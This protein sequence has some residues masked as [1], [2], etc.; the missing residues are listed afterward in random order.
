MNCIISE[1]LKKDNSNSLYKETKSYEKSIVIGLAVCA[2][3]SGM[4]AFAQENE[5]LGTPQITVDGERVELEK[6]NLTEYMFE[7]NSTVMVPVR[8]VA[9]KMGYTVG[10]DEANRA[11]TVET[12]NWQAMAYI[13]EDSYV[14]VSKTA[15]GMTAPVIIDGST[16]VPAKMFELMD[17]TYTSVGQYLDFKKIENT[18]IPNPFTSYESID[19]LQKALCFNAI[20]PSYLPDGYK[21]DDISAIGND[22][23]QIIYHD[24]NDNRLSYRMAK[25]SEDISGDYNVYDDTDTIAA[26][27]YEVTIKGSGGK[28]NCALWND[29]ETAYSIGSSEGLGRDQMQDIAA[30]I[31]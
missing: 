27:D 4:T 29:G 9:E 12:D 30:G 20:V 11:V 6:T 31:R 25:G 13:G 5:I 28:Y 14:G 18:Q 3:L 22:F 10:W 8:A 1:D 24:A 17:Y 2:L 21:I 19:E 15:I 23:M 7:E 26:G 16:F